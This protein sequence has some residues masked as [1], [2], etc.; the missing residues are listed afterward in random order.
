MQGFL[1]GLYEPY[2]GTPMFHNTV[3][4]LNSKARV[5]IKNDHLKAIKVALRLSRR[6]VHALLFEADFYF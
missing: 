5:D 2:G 6:R 3:H 1:F 4:K